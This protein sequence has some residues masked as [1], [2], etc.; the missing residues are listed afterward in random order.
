MPI[1]PKGDNW[2]DLGDG[3]EIQFGGSLVRSGDYWLI[4][5]RA[6]DASL[7]WPDA[8]DA[9]VPHP[10]HGIEVHRIPVASLRRD[11]RGW[12]ILEDLRQLLE[13]MTQPPT[14]AGSGSGTGSRTTNEAG[15]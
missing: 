3:V 14:D 13:P 4:A 15:M 11:E 7:T 6:A 5:A 9:S 10:P 2:I 12:T 1:R 8:T